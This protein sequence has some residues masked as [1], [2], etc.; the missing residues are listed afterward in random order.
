MVN[1]FLPADGDEEEH[2]NIFPMRKAVDTVS[3]RD[4]KE[5]DAEIVLSEIDFCQSMN[6][7]SQFL[8][9][10]IFVSSMLTKEP[11]VSS[12]HL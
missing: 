5:V 1:Y 8:E 11:S 12:I 2:C 3:L 4:V 7:T 6:R 9:C 10:I